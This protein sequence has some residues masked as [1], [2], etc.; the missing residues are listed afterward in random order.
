MRTRWIGR[1]PRARAALERRPLADARRARLAA[2]HGGARYA[3]LI[4]GA[5]LEVY[6]Y[7]DANAAAPDIDRFD[8]LTRNPG[9]SR[10]VWKK[11][12]ALVSANNMMIMVLTADAALRERVRDVLHLSHI[13]ATPSAAP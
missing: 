8:R 1:R 3:V 7:G 6:L 12:P 9:D 11:P 13:H 5:E 4:P 2:A 10:L